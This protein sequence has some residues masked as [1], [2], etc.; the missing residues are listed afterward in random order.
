MVSGP[1]NAPFFN[2]SDIT[3]ARSGPGIKAPLSPV[4]NPIAT[5][6]APIKKGEA[7]IFVF[8]KGIYSERYKL[9]L[10]TKS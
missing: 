2:V 5:S 9:F 3:K 1:D 6:D 10:L 8:V 7:A 4:R